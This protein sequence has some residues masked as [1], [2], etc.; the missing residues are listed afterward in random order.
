MG[1]RFDS[2]ISVSPVE[3]LRWLEYGQ[4][5]ASRHR[6]IAVSADSTSVGE[7]LL[8]GVTATAARSSGQP[9]GTLAEKAGADFIVLDTDAPHFAG[10]T[11]EDAIDR[12]IFSGNRNLVRDV[13]VGGERCCRRSTRDRD[14]I[15]R[16]RK[17]MHTLLRSRALVPWQRICAEG[18]RCLAMNERRARAQPGVIAITPRTGPSWRHHSAPAGTA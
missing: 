10:A 15:A 7:T 12:W 4:R 8:H 14:A 2:H 3:E 18:F 9:V 16:H 5:L 17:A 1:H 6:N 11:A 13:H